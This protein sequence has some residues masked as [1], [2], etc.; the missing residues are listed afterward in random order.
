MNIDMLP[1]ECGG[2][3]GPLITL[4]DETT[5]CLEENRDWFLYDQE[6]NR[7]NEALRPEKGKNSLGVVL[8]ID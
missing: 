5:K 6:N 8:E 4:H 3:A 2:K 1:D 7:V